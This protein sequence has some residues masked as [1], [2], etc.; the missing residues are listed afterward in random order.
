MRKLFYLAIIGA[1]VYGFVYYISPEAKH[2]ALAAVGLSDFF[3]EKLPAYLRAK[4]SIQQNPVAK[5]ERL[6]NELAAAIGGIERELDGASPAVSSPAGVATQKKSADSGEVRARLEKAKELLDQS[7]DALA[8]LTR[9]NPEQE[10]ILANA[11]GRLLDRILPSSAGS[12][13][14]TD[15]LGGE[16]LTCPPQ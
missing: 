6:L 5:R 3:R 14:A 9:S 8:E 10:G 16:G 7:E 13:A 11:A 12:R 4:L 1:A 2:R 15:G